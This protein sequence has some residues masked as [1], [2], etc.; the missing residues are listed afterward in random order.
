MNRQ[1]FRAA[2]ERA[3]SQHDRVIDLLLI[4]RALSDA[5]PDYDSSAYVAFLEQSLGVYQR[6]IASLTKI[7]RF[8]D[9]D[10]VRTVEREQQALSDLD[11]A[12][13]P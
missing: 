2:F 6:R 9:P 8:V 5:F 11:S 10:Y 1:E 13:S 4:E 12:V 3:S 7:L